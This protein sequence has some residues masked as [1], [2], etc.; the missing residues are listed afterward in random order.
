M[1]NDRLLKIIY[2][3]VYLRE[4]L[5]EDVEKYIRWNTIETEWTKWDAPWEKIE[6]KVEKIRDEF[7]EMF[8]KP[9]PKVSGRLNICYKDDTL[10]GSVNAYYIG[11]DKQNLAI[12]IGIRESSYWGKGLGKQAFSLW[13]A[14]LFNTTRLDNI[15]TETWSGN[16]R[17]IGLAQDIGFCEVA[18][19]RSIKTIEVDGKLFDGIVFNLKRNRF[20]NNNAQLMDNVAEQLRDYK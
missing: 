13:I 5:K 3:D 8:N 7:M 1:N 9:K 2:K 10:I 14:Y 15:Y 18:E 6:S 20:K 11:S 17:M 19:E 16:F 12:G 4:L